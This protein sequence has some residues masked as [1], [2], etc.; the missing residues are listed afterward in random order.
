[1]KIIAL[2]LLVIA[3]AAASAE[4]RA[5]DIVREFDK[6]HDTSLWDI[7]ETFREAGQDYLDSIGEK[8]AAELMAMLDAPVETG[9]R[10]ALRDR[11]FGGRSE[12]SII[13]ENQR[14]KDAVVTARVKERGTTL[15]M[16]YVLKLNA[17]GDWKIIALYADGYGAAFMRKQTKDI[18][19]KIEKTIGWE[20]M[21]TFIKRSMLG[22]EDPKK[23]MAEIKA[24][25][26]K[27]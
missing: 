3:S 12:F 26:E 1:M 9:A 16:K 18:Y 15:D 5:A 11:S 8:K 25:N 4:K 10:Q 17:A 13:A 27:P 23:V 21:K 7:K 20:G 14:E 22:K 2:I 6:T 19:T 24:A